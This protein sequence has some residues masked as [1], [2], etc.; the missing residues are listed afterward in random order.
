MVLSCLGPGPTRKATRMQEAAGSV[1]VPGPLAC[2]LPMNQHGA[3]GT[4]CAYWLGFSLRAYACQAV[5][6]SWHGFWLA[7]AYALRHWLVNMTR[8]VM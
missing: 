7:Q 4:A 8:F 3:K 1:A 6:C 5:G 2:E